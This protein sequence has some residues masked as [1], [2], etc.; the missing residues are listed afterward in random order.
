VFFVGRICYAGE[1]NAGQMTAWLEHKM[2]K[3]LEDSKVL[4]VASVDNTNDS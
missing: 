3:R 4:V 2:G 1:N